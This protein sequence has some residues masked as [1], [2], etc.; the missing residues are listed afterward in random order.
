MGDITVVRGNIFLARAELMHPEAVRQSHPIYAHDV[1]ESQAQS[2]AHIALPHARLILG[3]NSRLTF[4]EP[5]GD[6]RT[7]IALERGTL[8]VQ[9][10][11]D[12][13]ERWT[14]EILAA[15]S[16]TAT[17]HG[18]ITV[19]VQEEFDGEAT[20]QPL[21]ATIRSI[22]VINHGTQGEAT[23]EAMGRRV[24]VRPGY[25]SVTAPDHP[26][27]P[28][29][30]MELAKTFVNDVVQTTNLNQN[31]YQNN[32]TAMNPQTSSPSVKRMTETVAQ[33]ACKK[34]K[35]RALRVKPSVDQSK[36]RL[37]HCL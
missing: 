3:P 5:T 29:V 9:T 20:G 18:E 11:A 15:G 28:A 36:T 21:V 34:Q 6:R 33:R 27:T 7:I 1:L 25:L 31:Q 10:W 4:H 8:R 22:G 35:E 2:G 12:S 24:V 17:S 13:E 16:N 26:P 37:T 30:A 32:M 14:V 19:W 23:F